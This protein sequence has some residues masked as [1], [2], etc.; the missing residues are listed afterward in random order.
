MIKNI[1]IYVHETY[2]DKYTLNIF[3]NLF[4]NHKKAWYTKYP[5]KNGWKVDGN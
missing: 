5:V 4:A 3:K 1:P 2:M